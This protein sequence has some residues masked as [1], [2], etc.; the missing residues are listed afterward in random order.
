M[1]KKFSLIEVI[2]VIAITATLG[3]I[4][5]T[6]IKT[7]KDVTMKA[8]C[9]SNISQIRNYAELYRKDSNN[10]PYSEIWL[11]DFSWVQNYTSENALDVFNCPGDEDAVELDSFEKLKYSTSY[12]YVPSVTQLE[13]NFADGVALGITSNQITDILAS[14]DAVIYDKSPA[15][16][17]G[18][19]NIAHLF[20]SDDPNFDTDGEGGT[21]TTLYEDGEGT[22]ELLAVL[23]DGTIDVPD[24]ADDPVI[25]DE[26]AD[27]P[28]EIAANDDNEG[29]EE[30][31]K[32]YTITASAEEG[33][34]ISPAGDSVI[35][36]GGS[37]VYVITPNE[38]SSSDGKSNNGHGN[39]EDGV[40]SSNPGKSKQ[41]QDTDPN[42]DDENK[43]N[44]NGN[45]NGKS[46]TSY[47]ILDVK[48]DGVSVGPVSTYTFNDVN[49]NHTI[50][51]TFKEVV[52]ES[53]D[54]KSNNGHGNNEDGVDS[55]NP[56]NSKEGQDSDPNVDD[57][58]KGGSSNDN[59]GSSNDNSDDSGSVDS[60]SDDKS[61][62]GNGKDKDKKK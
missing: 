23:D 6:S 53:D 8:V 60:S 46:T 48:V 50:V 62:N 28:E 26:I 22:D 10:L 51:A 21:I 14:Q 41:G 56:G 43:D 36:E 47:E 31:D 27:D 54:G 57:E 38:G 58:S 59:S 19:I 39:N 34:S 7:S 40:D 20:K 1:K 25:A 4:L 13:R 16:H 18:S 37:K 55:S 24:L 49:A 42:E 2:A 32:D 35:N 61:N 29:E 17:N 33:G 5:I 12:Y 3:T 45:G 30:E 52:I 15:H 44:G 9:M 11:T